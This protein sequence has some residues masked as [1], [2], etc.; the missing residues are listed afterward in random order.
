MR[1]A[2]LLIAS[3]VASATVF[4]DE[5][6][7]IPWAEF[8]S[9]YRASVER[10]IM[11]QVEK[12]V[13]PQVHSIDEARYTLHVGSENAQGEMLLSGRI[14]SGKPKPIPLLCNDVVL[15][16]VG[17]V[18]GGT[19]FSG[20]DD[21]RMFLL[22]DEGGQEF[23]LAASFLV[24]LQEDNRSRIISFGIPYA[25]R[26]SLDLRLPPES[27]FVEDPGIADADGIYHFSASP[28]L[29]VR[30]LDKQG[31]AAAT[32][33][34][35][36]T[37]SRITVHENRILIYT[38]FLPTRSVP[39]S[40]ILRAPEGANYVSSSLK[41]SWMKR[42]DND[43]YELSIPP[44]EKGPFS[45]E[46]ALEAVTNDGELSFSLPAIEGNTG[47]QG[48]FVLEEP[49]DGPGDGDRAGTGLEHSGRKAG[50]S[51]EQECRG[52]PVV[53][54]GFGDRESQPDD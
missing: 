49:D 40:L 52:T 51:V 17:S 47:R 24:R 42:L 29:T 22:P 32:V 15:T 54:D 45:I 20:Q 2:V 28:R 1:V 13:P 44:G 23:Q 43:R 25:L 31:L 12:D 6:G 10:E 8:K 38:R 7:F 19:V 39:G 5:G 4:G 14:V 16:G 3:L 11:K 35:I 41:A 33:I 30:Y 50:P 18:T 27:R 48:R 34:E 26:N 36:D 21:N 46:F 37:L 53:H 9:L